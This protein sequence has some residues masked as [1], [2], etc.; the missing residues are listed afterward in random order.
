MCDTKCTQ[1]T[2]SYRALSRKTPIILR[3]LLTVA[4][5]YSS[6]SVDVCGAVCCS[7]LSSRVPSAYA[8]CVAVCCSVL[9][10]RITSSSVGARIECCSMLNC[11]TVYCSV[12]QCS[13]PT[14]CCSVLQCVAVCCS[15]L[16]CV[17]VYCSVWQC[18][19]PSNS[20]SARPM[21][22]RVLHSVLQ[23]VAQCVAQCVAVCCSVLQCVAEC[24]IESQNVAVCG[25]AQSPRVPS[26]H[27]QCI[28]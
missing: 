5:P 16:Q 15:A 26:A 18:S 24:H 20:I 10:C 17:A 27:V 23:S 13:D 7:C 14:V 22:C 21:C 1:P 9:Q 8:R 11:I 19:N 3:S 2:L 6:I 28:P 12:W 25:S 4:T